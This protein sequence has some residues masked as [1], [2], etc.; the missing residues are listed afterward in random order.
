VSS[1]AHE[2]RTLILAPT[3]RD[4]ATVKQ[5]L[6]RWGI[7]SHICNNLDDLIHEIGQ[8]VGAVF[9]AEEGLQAGIGSVI[10][11]AVSQQ[12]PWSDLPF[13]VL[14]S[15]R[16]NA[17]VVAWREGMLATLKNVSLL[18]RPVQGMTLVSAIR[19]ALRARQRQ[20]EVRALLNAAHQSATDLESVVAARTS[21]LESANLRL[22]QQMKE[23]AEIE[24]RLRHSQKI[25]AVGQLTGGVAHDFNNLLTVITGGLNMLIRRPERK[26][27]VIDA[28]RKAAAR[29]ARLT[30]QLLAFSRRQDLQPEPIDLKRYFEEVSELLDRSLRGDVTV[31]TEL[32][33]NVWP[34]I[35]DPGE[36]Q[37][38]ILN[39]CVNARDAMPNGGTI[40]IRVSNAPH[41]GDETRDFVKIAVGDNGVG[42]SEA[43]MERVF[44]PFFTTKDIGKGSGL[45]LAQVHG[46]VTQSGGLIQIES[47]VGDGTTVTIMLPRSDQSPRIAAPS[48]QEGPS[49]ATVKGHI[50]LVEDEDEVAALVS[51]M[52]IEIGYDVTRAASAPAAL[53][54][55]ANGRHIDMVFSD[56][57]MPGGMN[58]LEL[59][60]EIQR[61]MPG[62]PIL[63]TTGYADTMKA[64]A[65]RE[66][67]SLLA[68]P[69]E[70][71]D[72]E[73]AIERV[74]L[75][76]YSGEQRT[77]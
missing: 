33:E 15:K 76:A 72:L 77:R 71:S 45:G 57:M 55:L 51:Q 54:A 61:R 11:Q 60:R 28:M 4:G 49:P 74:R 1:T 53:G 14:S 17:K 37:L 7:A 73:A 70:L 75:S 44:E 35:A 12:P 25:E 22:Q 50:L 47:K 24:A 10:E 59:S 41:A 23:R 69:Y 64:E 30:H 43:V 2:L 16:E 36:L 6:D 31:V 27:E 13:V 3:G 9:V 32:A 5:L 68:K 56:M 21:E 48:S 20:Y 38:V 67:L 66:G 8:G 46:F 40:F 62:L 18:E 65:Q 58:G 19:T 26:N 39:L 29:G 52:L 63:L 42:M 34:I